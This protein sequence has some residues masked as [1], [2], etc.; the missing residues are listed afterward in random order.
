MNAKQC[1]EVHLLIWIQ[2]Q[3]HVPFDP[4]NTTDRNLPS[5]TAGMCVKCLYKGG[6]CSALCHTREERPCWSPAGARCCPACWQ[7]RGATALLRSGLHLLSEGVKAHPAQSGERAPTCANHH[8][9]LRG[10]PGMET[11]F[12]LNLLYSCSCQAPYYFFKRYYE[13]NHPSYKTHVPP[14]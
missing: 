4:A 9:K 6:H 5:D 3:I 8:T 14:F 10:P 12:S 7:R 13:M 1:L 2:T 11:H